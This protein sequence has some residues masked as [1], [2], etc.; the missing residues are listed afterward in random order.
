MKAGVEF[1]SYYERYIIL[2]EE[3]ALDEALQTGLEKTITF[4]EGI[5][6]SKH[7]Y[8]YAVGKWTPK[9]V[10]QHIIDTERVFAYRALQFARAE[11]V[12]LEGFDQD[13]FAKNVQPITQSMHAILGE[14][15]AVRRASIAFVKSCSKETLIRAGIASNSPLSVRAAFRII[16]GHEVHHMNIITERYL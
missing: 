14:F 11:N 2:G 8:R 15:V 10:L 1:N 6:D 16:A 5:P 7:E 3:G 13:E 4:F 12:V 9:E